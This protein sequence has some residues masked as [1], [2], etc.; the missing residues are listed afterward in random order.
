M[1]DFDTLIRSCAPERQVCLVV[2][3]VEST[4]AKNTTY[5]TTCWIVLRTAANYDIVDHAV[6][7]ALGSSN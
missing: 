5:D 1:I 4:A 6:R 3:V 2:V 7:V